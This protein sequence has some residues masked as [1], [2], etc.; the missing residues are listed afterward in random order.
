MR[1]LSPNIVANIIKKQKQKDSIYSH[2]RSV[3]RPVFKKR[4]KSPESVFSKM[5]SRK[6]ISPLPLISH[7]S[8]K[9][10]VLNRYQLKPEICEAF[11]KSIAYMSNITTLVLDNNGIKDSGAAH[12][13]RGI[14]SN[15]LI[16][17]FFYTRNEIGPEFVTELRNWA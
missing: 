1:D 13:I 8:G 7:T 14:Y 16:E 12:I 6:N 4:E 17:N 9:R 3:G 2:Y 5:W 10:L 15:N 11:G